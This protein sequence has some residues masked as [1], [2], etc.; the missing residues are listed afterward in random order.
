MNEVDKL[1]TALKEI[2]TWLKKDLLKKEDIIWIVDKALAET[3]KK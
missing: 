3:S 2:K 1:K